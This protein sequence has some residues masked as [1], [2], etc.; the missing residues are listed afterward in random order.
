LPKV[1]CN[2]VQNLMVGDRVL[3]IPPGVETFPLLLSIQKDPLYWADPYIW[4]PSRWILRPGSS[5]SVVEEEL[6]VARK[7]RIFPWSEGS[8]NCTGK[9]LSQVEAVAVLAYFFQGHGV[10]AKTEPGESEEHARKRAQNCANGVNYELLLKMN[11]PERV[12]LDCIKV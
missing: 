9:K 8:Q 5:S 7:G 11:H 12:S 1:A 2:R 3:A 10:R 4:R 6:F